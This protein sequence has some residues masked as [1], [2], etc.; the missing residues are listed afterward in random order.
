[1]NWHTA[2]RLALLAAAMLGPRPAL[3]Q[4]QSAPF[5]GVLTAI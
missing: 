2:W 4:A 3:L 5:E 1:M